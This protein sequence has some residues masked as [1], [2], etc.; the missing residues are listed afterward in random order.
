MGRR[1]GVR[2]AAIPVR[3]GRL[4]LEL[5]HV[6]LRRAVDGDPPRLHGFGNFPDQ[7]DL[8]QTVVKGRVLDLDVVGQVELPFEVAGRDA[9]IQEF[10]LSFLGLA[11]FDGDDVLLCGD[12]DFIRR[13]TRDR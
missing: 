13:E 1:P 3:S 10:A 9:A 5:V 12:R 7:S 6:G 11:A 2:T 4:G 8:E